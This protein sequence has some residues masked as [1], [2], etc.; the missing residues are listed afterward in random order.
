MMESKT[1]GLSEIRLPLKEAVVVG[2]IALLADWRLNPHRAWAGLLWANFF[3]VSLALAG[4]VFVAIQN[5]SSSGWSVAFRRVP[6]AMTAYLPVGGAVFA[7]LLL[8]GRGIF[9]WASMTD[10]PNAAY[11]NF[12]FLAARTAVFFGAWLWLIG[13]LKAISRRQDESSDP[14]LVEG[15]MAWSALF[16]VVFA[17]TFTLFSIDWLMALEPRW[18]STIYPW[19][20]FGGLFEGGLAALILIVL[21]L[22]SRGAYAGVNDHH[23]HDLGKYLFAFSVFWAYLW[24]S[25]YLLIW[26]SNLPEETVHYLARM[27]P[28]WRELFWLN[29]VVNLAVPFAILLPAARKK[30]RATLAAACALLLAGHAL[31]L[32]VL[33]MPPLLGSRPVLDILQ[34]LV[35]AGLAAAFVLTFQRAWAAAPETPRRDPY[36]EESLHFEGV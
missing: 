15:R 5:T 12:W 9:P 32:Y 13:K 11:L 27:Q 10:L 22:R 35:F 20:A 34:L 16:L 2:A 3:F 26:Y 14:A 29:P 30:R 18:T 1:R 4:A 36:L 7:L 33:I 23:L 8:A 19:Y 6:E 21:R 31:D 17:G 24:F 28:G 25:Q